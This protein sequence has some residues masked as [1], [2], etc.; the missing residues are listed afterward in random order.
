L[1][2][3]RKL[4]G[5]AGPDHVLTVCFRTIFG[6]LFA[7]RAPAVSNRI[8]DIGAVPPPFHALLAGLDLMFS[9]AP[10]RLRPALLVF[11]RARANAETALELV[12]VNGAAWLFSARIP[13]SS[14]DGENR[15]GTLLELSYF[16]APSALDLAPC[17]L[18]RGNLK[19]ARGQGPPGVH[20]ERYSRDSGSRARISTSEQGRPSQRLAAEPAYFRISCGR[21]QSGRGP[22]ASLRPAKMRAVGQLRRLPGKPLLNSLVLQVPRRLTFKLAPR[23]ESR[24]PCPRAR[25]KRNRSVPPIT[26]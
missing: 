24:R 11:A 13:A 2:S 19:R 4:S 1:N 15:V 25:A 23:A 10:T 7:T 12:P 3:F 14:Q 16:T 21:R 26:Q 17:R 9:S 20:Q 8:V 18:K 22:I 5:L 6:F